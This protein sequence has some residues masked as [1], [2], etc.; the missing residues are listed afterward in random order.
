MET[1]EEGAAAI[2]KT[3]IQAPVVAASSQP[4]HAH[5]EAKSHGRIPLIKFIGKRS[6]VKY[7]TPAAPAVAE[8]IAIAPIVQKFVPI[9]APSAK[10]IKEGTGVDFSTLKGGAMF[11]RPALSQREMDAIESGGAT[12]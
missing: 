9:P 6:L 10:S 12:N 3:T 8:V 2:T 1:S 7:V 4:I 11:G 5:T